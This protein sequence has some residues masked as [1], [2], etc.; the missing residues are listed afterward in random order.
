MRY[1]LVFGIIGA[2]VA[3]P[4]FLFLHAYTSWHL[5]AVWLAALSAATFAVYGIDKLLSKVSSTR[6]PEAV[7]DLLALMGGF[8]GGWAGMVV[9]HHKT[10]YR[11]HPNIWLFLALATIGHAALAYFLFARGS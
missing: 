8:G 3:V 2:A 4:L 9:F 7:L 1:A 6:A 11:K 5:Y 10:N